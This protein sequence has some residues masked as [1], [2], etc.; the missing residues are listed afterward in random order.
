MRHQIH[1]LRHRF[2]RFA[3]YRKSG[4]TFEKRFLKAAG[5]ADSAKRVDFHIHMLH[6]P[7]PTSSFHGLIDLVRHPCTGSV[8]V[9]KTTVGKK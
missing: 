7:L 8:H 1:D 4:P 9:F 3:F 5:N 2:F 6:A